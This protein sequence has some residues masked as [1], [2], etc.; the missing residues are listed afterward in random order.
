MW[1]DADNRGSLDLYWIGDLMV[2]AL[3]GMRYDAHGVGRFLSNN[4]DWS[5]ADLTA[6][7]GLFDIPADRPI[8]FG[9]NHAGRALASVDLNGD[10]FR[11]LV[12]TNASQ[13]GTPDAAARDFLNP[14]K[15]ANHWLP[16]R[17]VGT[18]SNRFGIGAVVRAQVGATTH[19]GEILS[20]TS[21]FTGVQPEAHF[22]LGDAT[23]VD[24]LEIVWPSGA[25][26]V[27]RDVQVDQIVTV[28]ES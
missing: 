15:T 27:L 18:S 17:L 22:C 4:G 7:R 24:R 3:H 6:E 12:L 26:T 1:I 16:V 25:R 9:Q 13:M 11:D 2:S 20:T 21:S 19:I 14:A 10:G 5:F 8:A 28:N 23:S